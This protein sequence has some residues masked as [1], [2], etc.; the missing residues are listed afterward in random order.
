MHRYPEPRRAG[1]TMRAAARNA[2]ICACAIILFIAAFN[3]AVYYSYP[4]EIWVVPHKQRATVPAGEFTAHTSP[5]SGHTVGFR[6]GYLRTEPPFDGMLCLEARHAGTLVEW[7]LNQD[8]SPGWLRSA[9][10][11]CI[12]WSDEHPEYTQ[13]S[14]IRSIGRNSWYKYTRK[15]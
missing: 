5:T 11:D 12:L 13:T 9:A 8:H 4:G 15:R 7:T 2:L 14:V 1:I 10:R 3:I 6:F